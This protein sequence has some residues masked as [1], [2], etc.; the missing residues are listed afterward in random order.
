M[1]V[2]PVPNFYKCKITRE[3]EKIANDKKEKIGEFSDF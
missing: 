1:S 3:T 2:N